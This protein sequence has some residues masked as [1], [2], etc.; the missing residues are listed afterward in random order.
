MICFDQQ[1]HNLMGVAPTVMKYPWINLLNWQQGRSVITIVALL[2][3]QSIELF[4]QSREIDSLKSLSIKGVRASDCDSLYMTSIELMRAEYF[5]SANTSLDLL[6]LIGEQRDDSLQIV[7]AIAI[8]ASI[9]RRQGYL[10]SAMAIYRSALSI[11][12]RKSYLEQSKNILN[13]LGL[14]YAL[15]ARYDVALESLFESLQLRQQTSDKF[16]LS[17]VFHN[18]GLVYYKLE[19][20]D[21]AL[22]YYKKALAFKEQIANQH[23]LDQLLVNIGWCHVKKKEFQIGFKYF[24]EAFAKCEGTCSDK[25][26]IDAFLGLGYIARSQSD[27]ALAEEHFVNS[28]SLAI[29]HRDLRQ[30]LDNIG[31]LSEIYISQNR[32][33]IAEKYLTEAEKLISSD[34]RYRLELATIYRQYADLYGKSNNLKRKVFFQ[35]KYIAL[36]DS[37]FNHQVTT[38]LMKAESDYVER[39]S[40]ARIEV[41][42]KIMKL[43]DEIIFRQQIANIAFGLVALFGVSL[44]VM[45]ARQK[46]AK[47]IANLLLDKKVNERTIE[48][49]M[50]Q[51][52]TQRAL[53][54]KALLVQKTSS[55]LYSLVATT[56]GLCQLGK[57]EIDI[58]RS[59]EYWRRLDTTAELMRMT[60]AKLSVSQYA[61][62]RP[63]LMMKYGGV[64][65]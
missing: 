24:D 61:N 12:K 65:V 49:R 1:F 8:K 7:R 28:Y 22:H 50:N 33:A 29:K 39:E 31:Q 3:W 34:D 25:L 43:N 11:A 32:M 38:N 2:S 5:D 36:K 21:K 27:L 60:I 17:V 51:Q 26:L 16:E 30:A 41:Q 9:L 46:K 4:S 62:A 47:Q 63:E 15:E 13:S 19:N 54:E 57:Q 64:S 6:Y 48:L 52:A 14:L 56:E 59:M 58:N 18:I 44:A 35:E 23:D 45:F 53:E 42:D 10:D 55:D 40:K 37:I 20:Y